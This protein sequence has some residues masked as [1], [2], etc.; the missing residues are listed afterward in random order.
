MRQAAFFYKDVD[1]NDVCFDVKKDV[2]DGMLVDEV[3][4]SP[5]DAGKRAGEVDVNIDGE[6]ANDVDREAT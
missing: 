2:V 4:S 6:A 5:E 1:V 3:E